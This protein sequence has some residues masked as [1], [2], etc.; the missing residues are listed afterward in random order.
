LANRKAETIT[1]LPVISLPDY[2]NGPALIPDVI[3]VIRGQAQY[4]GEI[5]PSCD[6]AVGYDLPHLSSLENDHQRLQQLNCAV[7]P[8]SKTGAALARAKAGLE[9]LIRLRYGN[10][11]Q[12][13]TL[14][15]SILGEKDLLKCLDAIV[16]NSYRT[17]LHFL[18]NDGKSGSASAMPFHS[19]ALF[20]YPMTLPYVLLEAAE[21]L[22]QS[23]WRSAL[24]SNRAAFPVGHHLLAQRP[25]RISTLKPRFFS[26]IV[27]RFVGLL[28]RLGSPDFSSDA[29]DHMVQEIRC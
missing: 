5:L 6:L 27:A 26:D 28:V 25:L 20:R 13:L 4:A 11:V 10:R 21:D 19:V 7:S 16:R 12:D 3:K 24:E 14:I 8:T 23:D 9:F 17:D 1:F 29:I 22:S 15:G 2:L 18:P